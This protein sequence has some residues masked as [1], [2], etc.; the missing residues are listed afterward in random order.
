MN[1]ENQLDEHM[2]GDKSGHDDHTPVFQT[3]L[4]QTQEHGRRYNT[5]CR[6]VLHDSAT[7]GR[8]GHRGTKGAET[9]DAQ[10]FD[11]V[12]NGEGC[13]LPSRLFISLFIMKIVYKSS[14]Q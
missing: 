4:P 3:E 1:D 9:A 11:W 12:K 13:P 14:T 2:K 10:D 8:S 7:R 5:T 6:C